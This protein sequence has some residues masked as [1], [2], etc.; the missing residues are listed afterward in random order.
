MRE[1]LRTQAATL[2]AAA[3]ALNMKGGPAAAR[4]PFALAFLSDAARGPDPMLVARALP[5][6]AALVL[7]DY[8]EPR[9]AARARALASVC[10]A[11]GS[12]LLVGGDAALAAA[13]GAAGVHLRSDQLAHAPARAGLLLTASCHSA[14]ELERAAAI[15]A[16]LAFLGP[17]FPTRSHPGAEGLG[18]GRFRALAEAAPLP[19]LALG[20]VDETNARL[21]A[22]P[23]VAGFGAIGAF[24]VK[25]AGE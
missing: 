10:A 1:G 24:T 25:A 3:R 6:G 17:V 4:A 7:R 14:E 2:A 20:G 19:V 11:R 13:V 18:A 8:N 21:L 16:D 15:G 5:G 22:G 9:R 23:N 12:L